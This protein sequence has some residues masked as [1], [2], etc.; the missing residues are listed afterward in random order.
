MKKYLTACLLT[1]ATS[2]SLI[3]PAKADTT[4]Y[5]WWG[6]LGNA[7]NSAQADECDA[8][9]GN[10]QSLPAGTYFYTNP[11]FRSKVLRVTT[12]IEYVQ[13]ISFYTDGWLFVKTST[14]RAWI[15]LPMKTSNQISTT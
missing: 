7:Q 6:C 2:L 3:A 15:Y 9:F 14:G 10:D 1:I 5:G 12:T 13:I 4:G 11:D 8:F